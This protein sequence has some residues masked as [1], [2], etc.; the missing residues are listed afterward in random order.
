VPINYEDGRHWC[1]P[2]SEDISQ[3]P[4]TCPNCGIVWVYSGGTWWRQTDLVVN[5]LAEGE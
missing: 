1:D 5:P 2:G 4:W 3:S